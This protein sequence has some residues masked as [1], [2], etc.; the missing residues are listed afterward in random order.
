MA[1]TCK[2]INAREVALLDGKGN[3]VLVLDKL[4]LHR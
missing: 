4:E 2:R 1:E 3:M